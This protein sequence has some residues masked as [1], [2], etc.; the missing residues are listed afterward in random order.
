MLSVFQIE[1]PSS[2][3]DPISN[4]FSFGGEQRNRGV[5]LSVFG[6]A[7]KGVR[8]IGGLAYTQAKLTR[9]A[10]AVNQGR[11]ATGVPQ[12]QAKLGAEYD[13]PWIP[14]LTLTGNV[15]IVSKQYINTD[16]SLSVPGRT[17]FD[18]GAR[19]ATAI[20]THPLT[21]RATVQNVANKAYWAG[22][23][24]SGLGAAR[25]FLL[26]ASLEY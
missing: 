15:V 3:T 23:L 4:V 9:T 18:L 20:G 16:N 13:T 19:Y 5:E 6:E 1:R 8:V 10:D 22:S 26:S 17:V 14:R 11:L 12:W 7:A 21:L 25:T 2:Y 24:G